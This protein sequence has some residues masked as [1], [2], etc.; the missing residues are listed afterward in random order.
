M[1][2]AVATRRRQKAAEA[3]SNEACCPSGGEINVAETERWISLFTGGVLVTCGLL[4][5]TT[6]GLVL[7]GIG[8]ALAYRGYSGH[9]HM[10]DAIGYSTAEQTAGSD[11]K[12]ATA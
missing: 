8:A 1:N 3:R 10:Y 6:S 12:G 9:C 5:G 4:R 7:A 11:F 2:P